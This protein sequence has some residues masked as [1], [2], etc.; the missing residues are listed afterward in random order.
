MTTEPSARAADPRSSLAALLSFL[1]P[2]LGQAYNGRRALAAMLL[3]PTGVLVAAV[4]I[5][6]LTDGRTVV[7]KL[8]SIRFLVGL[9]VLDMALLGWRVVAIVQAHGDRSRLAIRHWTGWVT[10]AL[11]VVTLAMHLLPGWYVVK[12]I[13]TIGTVSLEG[14]GIS[15]AGVGGAGIGLGGPVG[16]PDATALPVPSDQ[17]KPETHE[18]VN[19]LLVGVDSGPGRS[20]ALTDTML[21]ASLDPD[22]GPPGMVSIPRD[23]YG[24]P[25][26]DGRV[27]NAKLNSLMA[28]AAMRPDEYPLGGV[29]TLKAAIGELLGVKIHYFG[30]VNLLGFRQAV[31]AIG[32]VDIVVQRAVND[33]FY[34]NEYDK[35]TGFYISPGPHHLDGTTAL[36]FAR[37][38]KGYGDSDFTRADRQQQLLTAIRQKLTAGNLVFALPGLLDAV[39][40]TI[41]TDIPADQFPYLATVIQDANASELQ[42]IVLTPPTYMTVSSSQAA[43]YILIPNLDAIREVGQRLLDP[44]PTPTP[45]PPPER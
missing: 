8:L 3:L 25:L 29:G 37:S 21:V 9:L 7:T 42:R 30:A 1:V 11:V 40:N 13:D 18:R 44:Q 32:G 17:P 33:P 23:L 39:K 5:A 26:P 45:I 41:S 14:S 34:R 12:A 20:T 31:E 27:Y 36:A 35:L 10:A 24:V 15:R 6:L 28:I 4:A 43:G 38:R 16:L 2:G 19:I 22:G